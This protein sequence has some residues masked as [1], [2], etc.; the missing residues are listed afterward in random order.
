MEHLWIAIVLVSA[1]LQTARNAGQ[2]H[3]SGQMSA[4]S[5]TWVRFGYGLPF[6]VAYLLLAMHWFGLDI[7]ELKA[8][9]LIPSA[10]AALLQVVGT[11]LLILLFRM[12]NF[13]VGS[14]Y[15]R[16]EAIIVAIL[17]TAFFG[18]TV[19]LVGWVAIILSVAGVVMISL[20]RS[21]I[22]GLALIG[23]IFNPSAGIGLSAGLAYGLGS[24]FIRDASLSFGHPNF[25]LTAAITLVTVITLQTVVLGLYILVTQ[26]RDF[27]AIAGLW[28]PAL[29]VGVTSAF[30]S[31]GWFTAMTIQRVSYVKALAQIEFLF[32]LA[33]SILFFHENPTRNEMVGMGLVAVG[34]AI[35]VLFAK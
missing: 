2:K 23:S 21:G 17:G 8:D 20:V 10:I 25:V 30:G 27:I 3:L 11:V 33:V 5:A 22:G 9:F 19:G 7:P 28:K 6:A 29:F 34:I 32:A 15:V 31:M 1:G 16:S 35:L 18:E 24:F 13:A 14:T 26:P 4:L 12:R